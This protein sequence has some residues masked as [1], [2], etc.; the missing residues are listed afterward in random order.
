MGGEWGRGEGEY[1]TEVSG[2]WL[3]ALGTNTVDDTGGG[4]SV[5]R[6]VEELFNPFPWPSVKRPSKSK[7]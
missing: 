2:L 5:E 4:N 6:L 3:S 1:N 7:F